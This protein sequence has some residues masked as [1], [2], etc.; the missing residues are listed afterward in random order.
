MYGSG[1][2]LRFHGHRWNNRLSVKTVSP[3]LGNMTRY[4]ARF[5]ASLVQLEVICFI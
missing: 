5:G 4:C 3:L 2:W 1:V